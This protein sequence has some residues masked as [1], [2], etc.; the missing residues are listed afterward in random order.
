MIGGTSPVIV[1]TFTKPAILGSLGLPLVF[2]VYL[3]ENLTGV[4]SDGASDS[5]RID[6]QVFK[7]IAFQRKVAQTLTLS[8]RISKT[9]VIGSTVLSLMTK[10]YELINSQQKDA[11]IIDI[12]NDRQ[13]GG[14]FVTVYHDSSFMLKGYLSDFRKTPIDNTD[15]YSV[16]MSFN[17]VPSTKGLTSILPKVPL[18]ININPK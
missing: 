9:N 5:I 11:D 3:D 12:L 7:N 13:D 4:A 2:P 8:M 6:T 16:S 15:M 1:F 18:D 17:S 10:I 14:Y